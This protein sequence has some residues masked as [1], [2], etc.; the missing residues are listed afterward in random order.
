MNVDFW[1]DF[2]A[3]NKEK[4]ERKKKKERKQAKVDCIEFTIRATSYE[5][6]MTHWECRKKVLTTSGQASLRFSFEKEKK[7]EK[8]KNQCEM[9]RNVVFNLCFSIFQFHY[10][11]SQFVNLRLFDTIFWQVQ[12]RKYMKNIFY[13][14]EHH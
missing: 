6:A 13:I 4:R 12:R 11:L 3:Q 9:C 1:R 14:F 8:A 2:K 5:M 10:F 7:G